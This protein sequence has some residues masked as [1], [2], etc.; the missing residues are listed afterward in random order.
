M[1]GKPFYSF[2]HPDDRERLKAAALETFASKK[3]FTSFINRNIHKYG[4]TVILETSGVPLIGSDG[5]LLGYRGADQD[6]TEQRQAEKALRES[7]EKLKWIIEGS[8]IPIFTINKEHRITQWNHACENLTGLKFTKMMGTSNQ[9]K[10]FYSGERPVMVDFIINGA[11]E[12]EIEKYYQDRYTKSKLIDGAYEAEDFFPHLNRWLR[13]TASPIR[14]SVGETVGALE[15]LEDITERKQAEEIYKILGERLQTGIYVVQD[16]KFQFVSPKFQEISGFSEDELLGRDSLEAIH[17]EDRQMVRE[18]VTKMLKGQRSSPYEFRA[19]TKDGKTRWITAMVTSIQYKGERAVLGNYMDITERKTAEKELKASE[20]RYRVLFETSPL[21]LTQHD[22]E[23]RFLAP[24][25]A[26]AACVGIPMEKLAGKKLT[27]VFPEEVAQQRLE[28]IRKA[29]DEWQIQVFEDE[30]EGKYF[31]VIY[32]PTRIPGQEDTVQVIARDITEQKQ[33]EEELWESEGKYRVLTEAAI[34]AIITTGEEGRILL[35]N[36]GAEMMF[37]YTAEEATGKKL[38]QLIV[39]QRYQERKLEGFKKFFKTGTGPLIDTTREL[40]A[41]RKNG[42]EFSIEISVAPMRIQNE[43]QSVAIIRDITE[44]KRAQEQLEHSFVDL[45]E[46]VSRAMASRDPYTSDHQR[47]VAELARL[48]GEKMGLDKNRLRGL[49]IGGLLH[50]I[51]KVSTPES[52]LAKPGKLSHE[53]WALIRAHAKQG[54]DILNGSKFP[55]PIADMAVHHHER[56]DGSGY[57]DGISGGE[58]SLEIRILTVCNVVEAMSSHRPYRP[59]RSKEEVL[60]EIKSGRGTK[61]DANVVDI[62][63]EIIESGEFDLGG[64]QKLA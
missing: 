37:G 52:I 2:F 14:N 27:E 10:A 51:G 30:R 53:E 25:P 6:V 62:V 63:L 31:H 19:V 1:I 12:H 39:P 57:P 4:H 48:V 21:N 60:E 35:W 8:P 15:T 49:Y 28:L 32:A 7:E 34:D 29:L 18:N 33:A 11:D 38:T 50:D 47:R 9:W 61:Y 5:Q 43:W 23:G 17:S 41:L 13:F 42:A 64:E 54:Y 20:E 40:T 3:S 46:T 16:R 22:R 56:L 36:R 58:V 55:W 44:R 45:A 59:A 24:N 26:M